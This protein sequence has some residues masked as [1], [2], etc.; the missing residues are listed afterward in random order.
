MRNGVNLGRRLVGSQKTNDIR[1]DL[2]KIQT[3]GS[4]PILHKAVVIDVIT[5][6]ASLDEEYLDKLSVTVNNPELVDVMPINSIIARIVS[7]EEGLTVESN[8]IVFPFFQSHIMLPIAPGELVYVIYEDY[9]GTGEKLGYWITRMH[10]QRTVEDTNYTHADRRFD[11]RNNP[12]NYTTN[13]LATSKTR[14]NQDG[15]GF[16]NGGGTED[17]YTLSENQNFPGENPYDIIFENARASELLTMEPVPRWNKRPQEL[18]IQGS[19]NTLICLG[20]DRKGSLKGAVEGSDKDSKKDSGT[21]DIVA[22]RGRYLKKNETTQ[23]VKTQPRIVKNSRDTFE[24]DKSPH[25]K[26]LKDNPNEGDPDFENDAARIYVSMQTEADKNFGIT[27]ISFTPNTLQPIQPNSGIEG[28]KNKGYVVA[29]SDHVRVI[30][31]KNTEEQTDGTILLLKEGTSGQDLG[32]I[33]ITKNGIQIEAPKIYI[34]AGTGEDEPYILWSK[35]KETVENLHGQ[36]EDVRNAMQTQI[37]TLVTTLQALQTAVGS[38]MAGSICIPF[39]PD[40]AVLAAGIAFQSTAG[41]MPTVNTPLGPQTAAQLSSNQS[42]NI[43]TNVEAINHSKK[44]FGE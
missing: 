12:G 35:Y 37:D 4:P 39:G 6:T 10:T 2:K 23:P 8:T 18:V 29:K 32:Y 33:N 40:P 38:A 43:Q 21:I 28:T 36:I 16:Q 1:E 44:T 9:I 14:V 7:N 24:V 11:A 17:T 42:N 41:T 5:D 19:N 15:P 22:G 31:R 25:I 34:G 30:A 26:N 27:D 3:Q 20:E 13:D